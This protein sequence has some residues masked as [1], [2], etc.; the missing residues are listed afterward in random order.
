MAEGILSLWI[1]SDIIPTSAFQIIAFGLYK[2]KD[3]G[4]TCH[5]GKMYDPTLIG[6]NAGRY[7]DMGSQCNVSS[8]R[9]YHDG[10]K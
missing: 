10:K 1:Y 8:H 4:M 3:K 9:Q 7:F 2:G 6:G 5:M